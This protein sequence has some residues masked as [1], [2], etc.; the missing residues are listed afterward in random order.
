M[1]RLTVSVTGSPMP[2]WSKQFNCGPACVPTWLWPCFVMATVTIKSTY[3][4]DVESVRMLEALADRWR[5]SK[6]EALR[7][8]IRA[9][10]REQAPADRA[11]LDALDRL[12]ASVRARKI[13]LHGWERDVE[14][15]RRAVPLPRTDPR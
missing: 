1:A 13:D 7:R 12:Q 6:S 9:A 2:V 10:A 3:A 4:L 8:A 11:A 5:V 14:A 15:E